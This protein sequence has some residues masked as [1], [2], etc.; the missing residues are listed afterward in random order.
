[1]SPLV[2][3]VLFDLGGVL[4]DFT[5][6]KALRDLTGIAS[7]E[8]LWQRWLTCSWVRR[9][10]SGACSESA[11]AD[12]I[13]ADWKLPLSSAGFL[14]AFRR[15]PVG[16]LP[17]AEE[18][19]VQA[20]LAVTV[21]CASNTNGA[22]WDSFAAWPLMELFDNRFASFQMGLLKPDAAFFEQISGRLA[23]P[24]DRVLFLDDNMVNVEG[25]AAAGFRARRAV[26]VLQA[27][28]CLVEVGV[29][30][31]AARRLHP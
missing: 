14:E 19:V 24:P 12:G 26:G 28:E 5:G 11:F 20:K 15:W 25:A 8:E 7:E 18:L 21:G 6:V 17:G 22:H 23:L 29:L 1:M 10:E 27:R 4:I 9:F 30:P 3:V 31:A 16:P 2:D 13:V